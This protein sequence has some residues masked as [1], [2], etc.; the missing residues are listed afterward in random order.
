MSGDPLVFGMVGE[1]GQVILYH[2]GEVNHCPTC[3]GEKWY[4]GRRVAECVR[5]NAAF[6]LVIPAPADNYYRKPEKEPA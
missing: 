4:I 3:G 5:C 2:P 1:T 6:P